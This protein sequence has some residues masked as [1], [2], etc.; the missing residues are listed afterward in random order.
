MPI[1]LKCQMCGEEYKKPA[2]KAARSK[3]CSSICRNRGINESKKIPTV[4][5][6]CSMCKSIFSMKETEDKKYCSD[7][8]YRK[9][10][11]KERVEL[12][13]PVC[14]KNFK[15]IIGRETKHCSPTCRNFAQSSGTLSIPRTTRAGYRRDLPP[16]V[17]FKSA[18]EADYA[19]YCN[20]M[21]KKWYYEHKTF[22]FEFNNY[23]RAYT[24]DFYLPDQNLYVET[25]AKRRDS[26]YDANL[27]CTALLKKQ[28]V[29][30][31]VVF[32]H[33]FYKMLKDKNLYW[34][35]PHIENKDYN[36]TKWLAYQEHAERK[37][38]RYRVES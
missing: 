17:F 6:E 22:Q 24:P 27:A 10:I 4:E 31:E 34:L 23:I 26:K 21:K 36:G 11:T 12:K 20:Y 16:D 15:R 25:K 1:V 19:R 30:I 35:I 38:D 13:C 33:D 7:S 32:M 37:D 28:G 8:C 14:E 3:Y 2:S 29:N 9:D 18:L 5:K